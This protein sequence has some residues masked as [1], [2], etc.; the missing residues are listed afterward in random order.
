M[1]ASRIIEPML[2]SCN[3]KRRYLQLQA[4]KAIP[5]KTFTPKFQTTYSLDRKSYD[6]D[7]ERN[8][9]KKLANEYKKELKGAIRD[10]RNDA[11]F[12]VR[13]KVEETKRKDR[14]Y[15][16]KM[17]KIKGLLAEQE[18]SM[19]GFEREAKKKRSK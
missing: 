4:R 9:N 8:E 18:G 2:A 15:Q 12:M 5:I 13:K 10:L 17:D 11:S 7:R 14:E 16:K 6:P 1:E 19:R 3:L